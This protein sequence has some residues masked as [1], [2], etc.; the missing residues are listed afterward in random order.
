MSATRL[1]LAVLGGSSPFAASLVDALA[2]AGEELGPG[3]LVLHGRRLDALAAVGTYARRLLG[4]EGWQVDWTRDLGTAAEGAS[5]VLHQIRY[6]GLEGRRDDERLAEDLGCPADETLGPGG[7]LAAIRM[8]PALRLT[9][10]ELQRANPDA[11]VLNLTN[12]LSCSTALL[13]SAGVRRVVGL[14]EL[15]HTTLA[16]AC[17]LLRV[18]ERE[19]TWAYAGLNHRGF[20]Y[21][22]DHGRRNLLAELPERL[23]G[24]LL[25]GIGADA[26]RDLSA[27]PLKYFALFGRGAPRPPRRADFLRVLRERVLQELEED[28]DR[29]PPSLGL[30]S[31]NWYPQSVVPVLRAL[32]ADA[33]EPAVVNLPAAHGIV[34]ELRAT[35]SRGGIVPEAAPPPPATVA[36]WLSRFEEHERCVVAAAAEPTRRAVAAAVEADALVPE[37]LR[38]RAVQS[39]LGRLARQREQSAARV[40]R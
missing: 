18:P 23:G 24:A 39:I 25:G 9:A 38:R 37:Q 6:G 30:R 5:V 3:T 2:G 26:I 8:A 20:I 28:P 27:L 4:P 40:L 7:L 35:V 34:R 29:T 10:A 11:V 21:R 12:P 1:R 14:C 15:P 36:A 33:A 16:V 31:L 32:H 13:A 19:V 17:H 22:L